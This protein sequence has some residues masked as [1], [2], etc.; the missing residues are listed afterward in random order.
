[1]ESFPPYAL[2]LL[3]DNYVRNIPL[4]HPKM[5]VHHHCKRQMVRN[6]KTFLLHNNEREAGRH[7]TLLKGTE[8]QQQA[9]KKDTTL[10]RSSDS[11][12]HHP[13]L[14]LFFKVEDMVVP[15]LK[16]LFLPHVPA[17]F[18]NE[19]SRVSMTL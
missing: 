12:R 14:I 1:M 5:R 2:G 18:F 15:L 8:Q 10:I 9:A 7:S 4:C 3:Q 16:V 11:K 6:V 19:L 17:K 13:L